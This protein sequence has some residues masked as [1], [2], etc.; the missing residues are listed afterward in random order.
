L[1]SSNRGAPEIRSMSRDS[2]NH[3][4][5][6]KHFGVV[7]SSIRRVRR[8][9]NIHWIVRAGSERLVLRRYAPACS[10][11]EIAYEHAVLD[12]LQRRD[13][14]VA[15]PIAGAWH[16]QSA[17]WCVF[18][19]LPGR[20]PTPRS[21]AGRRAEH[22]A[23]GRLLARLHADL[24]D[25]T[26]LGQRDRWRTTPDGLFERSGKQPAETVLRA[27]ASRDP[28]RGRI[29]LAYA[30]ATRRRLDELMPHAPVP[31]VI[32]G[33]VTPWNVRYA[34]G[35]LSAVFDFDVTHLDL[36]VADFVLS[37]RG[38]YDDVLDGYEEESALSEVERELI[39]PVYRGWMIACAVEGL[40]EAGRPEWALTHLLR[41]PLDGGRR[42]A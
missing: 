11:S 5:A 37:W 2:E 13:W 10:A 41:Q 8:G 18:P 20:S 22:R 30:D 39:V 17:T 27:Y 32:H 7:A 35:R 40:E 23:R 28:D 34:R 6:L 3:F 33:D 14:P 9:R 12:H 19:Y 31:I 1:L 38:R 36:R 21:T 25:L 29:L 15:A 24:G 42:T 26:W 16:G 4:D